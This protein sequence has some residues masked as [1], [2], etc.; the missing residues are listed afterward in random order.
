MGVPPLSNRALKE[1]GREGNKV[2]R[3]D[4]GRFQ[5]VVD[6]AKPVINIKWMFRVAEHGGVETRK[7]VQ[8]YCCRLLI[9]S[10]MVLV[11]ELS[12]DS[13]HELTVQFKLLHHASHIVW[14]RWWIVGTTAM[15]TR[16]NH[17]AKI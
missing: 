13:F 16:S 6:V 5:L 11:R 15:T 3:G 8:S 9:V 10:M 4:I 1:V 7:V 2:G 14:R 17:P 12:H